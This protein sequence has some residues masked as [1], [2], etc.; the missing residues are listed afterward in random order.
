MRGHA[1]QPRPSIARLDKDSDPCKLLDYTRIGTQSVSCC[2]MR[3]DLRAVVINFAMRHSKLKGMIWKKK[4][5]RVFHLACG[6]LGVIA[7]QRSG[8]ESRFV[9]PRFDSMVRFARL[10]AGGDKRNFVISL[11]ISETLM[12]LPRDVI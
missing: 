9:Y 11:R 10:V 4:D 1:N 12:Q 5:L 7:L 2:L 8:G 3:N 6:F